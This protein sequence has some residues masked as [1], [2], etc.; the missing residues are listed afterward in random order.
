MTNTEPM[1][2]EL[3]DRLI[4][5]AIEAAPGGREICGFAMK[6]WSLVFMPNVAQEPLRF[7]MD[8]LALL[9]FYAEFPQPEGIFHS[10]PDGRE[11]PSDTDWDYAPIGLRYWIVTLDNVI[12]WDMSGDKPSRA[13]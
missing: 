5:A 6:D 12:E 8:D 9:D 1:P 11:E 2:E 13:A 7:R 10:H 3:R 4:E